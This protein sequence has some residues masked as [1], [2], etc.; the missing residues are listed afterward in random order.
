MPTKARK[1]CKEPQCGSYAV[2]DGYCEAHYETHIQEYRREYKAYEKWYS[3]SIWQKIKA[4]QLQ[5]EPLCVQCLKIGKYVSATEVDH[6]IPH[7]GN[8][9][10]FADKCN[11]QSLCKSCHSRKT[12]SENRGRG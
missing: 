5:K 8:W 1:Y 11:L 6:V 10:L 12:L 3:R 4:N 9:T 7:K 2:T